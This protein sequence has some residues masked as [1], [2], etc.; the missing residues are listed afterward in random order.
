VI[1]VLFSAE[2]ND[3]HGRERFCRIACWKSTEGI[4]LS[5]KKMFLVNHLQQICGGV[6]ARTPTFRKSVLR[7][8]SEQLPDAEYI[9][10][11]RTGL[12][13]DLSPAYEKLMRLPPPEAPAKPQVPSPAELADQR[14]EQDSAAPNR[15]HTRRLGR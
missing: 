12:N 6:S 10:G 1:G 14:H 2:N 7:G 5:R 3:L 8:L 15:G 4:L 13:G 9:G 11:N